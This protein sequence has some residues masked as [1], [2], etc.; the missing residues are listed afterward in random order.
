MPQ[1]SLHSPLG[2]LTLSEENGSLVALDW[3]RGRDQTKTPLLCQARDWLDQWFDDPFHA[4][5]FPLP[6]S[7][8]GTA[9]QKRVW[10]ALCTIPVGQTITYTELAQQCG[11]HA[12]SIGQAVARN[13]IPIIIPCHRVIAQHGLGGYSS[14]GGLEDKIWLLTLEGAL[15]PSIHT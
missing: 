1:L 15:H 13:P 5:K 2:D 4:D 10:A 11:G 3:G 6:L 7:P 14:D 8:F 9:Y 12:R